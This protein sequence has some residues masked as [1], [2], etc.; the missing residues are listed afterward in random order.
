MTPEHAAAK[1]ALRRYREGLGFQP[2]GRPVARLVADA[3]DVLAAQTGLRPCAPAPLLG[4][5]GD[6]GGTRDD[7]L[8]VDVQLEVHGQPAQRSGMH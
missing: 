3:F 2:A 8:V 7:A 4:V 1:A 6:G 5:E